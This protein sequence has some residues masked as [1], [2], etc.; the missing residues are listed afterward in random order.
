MGYGGFYHS[1]GS[2]NPELQ[3]SKSVKNVWSDIHIKINIIVSLGILMADVTASSA[4]TDFYGL[5]P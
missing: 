5:T 2:E 4:R 3:R 1:N